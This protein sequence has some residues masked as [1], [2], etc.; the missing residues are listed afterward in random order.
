MTILVTRL[1]TK[2]CSNQAL[3]NRR[4]S[5]PL[6][7]LFQWHTHRSLQCL[8][9]FVVILL[10]LEQPPRF[11]PAQPMPWRGAAVLPTGVLP[12]PRLSR[13]AVLPGEVR[14]SDYR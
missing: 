3:N 9:L 11:P 6:L 1:I 4:I 14:G 10:F 2:Q 5:P 13:L 7:R 8:H 12:A